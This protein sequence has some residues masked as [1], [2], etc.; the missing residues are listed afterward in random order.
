MLAKV[1][2]EKPRLFGEWF[3]KR[4]TLRF[5]L[6]MLL[7]GIVLSVSLLSIGA[8]QVALQI[9]D[10][11]L[12]NESAKVLN[13]SS[14]AIEDEL[15]KVEDMTFMILSDPN[16]Q[17][18][19]QIIKDSPDDYE[20]YQASLELQETLLPYAVSEGYITAIDFVDSKGNQVSVG[21][22]TNLDKAKNTEFLNEA[23]KKMGKNVWI[24]PEMSGEPLIAARVV[25]R[26]YR[27]GL[28]YLGVMIIRISLGQLVKKVS[29]ADPDPNLNLQIYSNKKNLFSTGEPLGWQD[30]SSILN[31][32][33]YGVKTINQEKL[34]VALTQA[35][36]LGWTYANVLPF[37]Q[38]YE[39]IFLVR[40]TMLLIYTAVFFIALWFGM[41]FAGNITRPI[42]SLVHKM[43]EV[44][45]GDFQI[46]GWEPPGNYQ[47]EEISHLYQDFTMMVEKID[48]LI[49]ENYQKQILLKD[50]QFKT[51]Q[52]QINPH[53]LYNT[54]DSVNW[55][56]KTNKELRISKM[57]EA[58]GRLLRSAV[59]KQDLIT[60]ADEE[61][62]LENY[63]TIQKIRFEERLNF[64]IRVE[65]E[66]GKCMIPKLTLQPIVENAVNYGLESKT[67]ICKIWVWMI[68]TGEMVEIF[69]EDNG[70]G[71]ESGYW[72][73]LSQGLIK[74]RGSGIGLKNIDD[75]IKM[76]F[77]EEY[78]IRV[79]SKLGVGTKVSIRI[80]FTI[81]EEVRT[82][83]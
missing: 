43:K 40:N 83:V 78:G 81:H 32:G 24:Q 7:F 30:L 53:F 31:N 49:K 6:F 11:Q 39:N 35:E 57:V 34:F 71:M 76:I 44:E 48:T 23:L 29:G 66:L 4:H 21:S 20:G 22:N 3:P 1:V 50:T 77:G 12:Y 36:Y 33:N 54:L 61:K 75:R 46:N 13:L 80:P 79:D 56:A 28:D 27:L 64:E 42:E 8:F 19:L 82:D 70:P 17:K 25:R 74:T 68:K 38:I 16:V 69:I 18:K 15:K 55:M 5:H 2:K 45:N 9:Y 52:A 47:I 41:K 10:Q 14:K 58:L 65:E 60:I 59:Y 73:K 63:I 72:E 62:I 67:G 37:A 26:T 51:L